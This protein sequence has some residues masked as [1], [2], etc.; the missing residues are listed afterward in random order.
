M[1]NDLTLLKKELRKTAL[2]KRRAMRPERRVAESHG[3][4]K[5]LRDF[6]LYKQASCVFCYV[7]VEDEVQTREILNQ[8]LADRKKLCVPYIA[9]PKTRI[10]TAA[11]LNSLPQTMMMQRSFSILS[12]SMLLPP[13][14]VSFIIAW[15]S[16]CACF[17]PSRPAIP[18]AE[19]KKHPSPL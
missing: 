10:M 2:I 5:Q 7:S 8:V 9:E 4:F 16:R 3:I 11:R 1:E 17:F 18:A 13:N 14:S 15:T 6:E 12:V 19:T